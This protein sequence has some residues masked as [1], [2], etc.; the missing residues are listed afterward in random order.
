MKESQ[1][2]TISILTIFLSSLVPV[3]SYAATPLVNPVT[4]PIGGPP[5]HLTPHAYDVNNVE[6]AITV[7]SA[8]QCTIVN[9]PTSLAT[10]TY[11]STGALLTAV[12]TGST[13]LAQWKCVNGGTTV[14]SAVFTVVVPWSVVAV[15][16]T[17]P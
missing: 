12:G 11:D 14:I 5:V 16:D 3:A 7:G 1:M 13:N 8:G 15:G 4:V 10:V 9:I 2:K 17:S 6:V